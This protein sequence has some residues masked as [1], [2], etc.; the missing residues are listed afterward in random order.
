MSVPCSFIGSLPN[1]AS[2]G[3]GQTAKAMA[4]AITQVSGADSWLCQCKQCRKVINSD[5]SMAYH[6]IDCVLYGWCYSCFNQRADQRAQAIQTQDARSA[7]NYLETGNAKYAMG[8]LSGAVSEYNKAIK[9]DSNLAAAYYGRGNALKADGSI[10]EA[11]SDYNKSIELNPNYSEAYYSRGNAR[12]TRQDI[13][14]AIADYD[15]TLAINPH[16]ALAYAKRGLALLVEGKSADAEKDFDR[17]LELSNN[18][19]PSIEER[20]KRIKQRIDIK[21]SV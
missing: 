5:E 11:I 20:I 13:R 16:C 21:R 9:I 14:G 10:D 12:L 18:A 2:K 17:F 3:L 8:E 6:L 19:N 15:K 4:K 1:S 7:M